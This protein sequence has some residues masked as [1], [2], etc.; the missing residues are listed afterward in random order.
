VAVRKETGRSKDRFK[1]HDL[2]ADEW[3]RRAVLDDRLEGIGG[4][5][6]KKEKYRSRR[7]PND[8]MLL[9]LRGIRKSP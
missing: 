9:L 4:W 8:S 6:L 7:V 3:C 5:S 2:F 1:V